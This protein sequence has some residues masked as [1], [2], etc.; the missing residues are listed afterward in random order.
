[1]RING[2]KV[3][4]KESLIEQNNM[5]MPIFGPHDRTEHSARSK[6]QR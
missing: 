4:P 3:S 1:M 2:R 5:K 6:K